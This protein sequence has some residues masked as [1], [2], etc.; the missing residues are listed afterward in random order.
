ME[1]IKHHHCWVKTVSSTAKPRAANADIDV[2]DMTLAWAPA[3][4]DEGRADAGD[5]DDAAGRVAASFRHGGVPPSIRAFDP[6][7]SM[8]VPPP[9]APVEIRNGPVPPSNRKMIF[10]GASL[11]GAWGFDSHDVIGGDDDGGDL[12]H[13]FQVIIGNKSVAYLWLDSPEGR[14]W[15]KDAKA[16]SLVT[17]AAMGAF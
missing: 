14:A 10:A 17:F 1:R 7:T 13:E 4:T 15:S 12:K 8:L 5:A 11:A 16:L 6:P 9:P 2:A 3:I